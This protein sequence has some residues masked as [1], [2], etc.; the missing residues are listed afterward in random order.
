VQC[1][2]IVPLSEPDALGNARS[3][4]ASPNCGVLC[5]LVCLR[6]YFRIFVCVLN[7]ETNRRK[8]AI[9]CTRIV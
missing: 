4:H 9:A 3:H 1:Y 7:M 2:Q 8:H 5:L 6:L